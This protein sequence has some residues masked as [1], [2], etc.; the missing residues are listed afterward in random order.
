M[1]SK[2]DMCFIS[3]RIIKRAALLGIVGT[4]LNVTAQPAAPADNEIKQR[5]HGFVGDKKKPPGVA[6]GLIDAHGSRIF[7]DGKTDAKEGRAIDADTMF[8]I[9]SVTKTFTAIVLEDMVDHKELA[10]DDP[11][12]KFLPPSVT[13]PTRNGKQITLI[14]LATQSSGLPRLPDNMSLFTRVSANPYAD[15]GPK[16]LYEFLS[17][18]KLQRDI[19]SQYEY[20]N[21]GFGLLGQILALRAG[22]NYEALVIDRICRPLKMESTVISLTPQLKE[23]LAPGHDASGNVTS[24]WDF[25]AIAGAG[26]VRSSIRDM[27]KFLAA[28]M[29]VTNT[30][31]RQTIAR[32]EEP[33]RD[34]GGM[35]RRIGLAWH[36]D[37]DGVVWHNGGTGGYRSFVGFSKNTGRGVVVLANSAAADTDSLGRRIIGSARTHT[38]VKIDPATFDQYVGKYKLAPGVIIAISREGDALFA[39]LTGQNRFEI[40]PEGEGEFF[41]KV[42]DAQLTFHK[43]AAGNID[44]VVLHQNGVDQKAARE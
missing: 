35:G 10:L 12:G 32:T 7:V 3:R 9:G 13:T 16:Q 27:V 15:Y 24:N 14:D 22:T 26:A 23:R 43:K 40:F 44:H 5:L 6:V 38:I 25:Q 17:G 28:S 39:Q 29:G 31:L 18:Y 36:I 33:R 1:T 11:I 41:F 37:T 4:S 8:E 19:G 42:V 21:L 2:N 34:A 20:S 30:G